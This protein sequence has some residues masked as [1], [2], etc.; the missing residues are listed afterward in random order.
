MKKIDLHVHTV[1]TI[2]DSQFVFSLDVFKRYVSEAKLEAV[3][4]TNH[5][6]FDG[7][8][9]RTIRDTFEGVAVFPGIEG[10]VGKGHVFI[11][12][13]GVTLEDFAAQENSV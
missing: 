2:S 4:V 8:Q 11:I 12:S 6:L 5:D 1:P 9:F 10:N 3:A 13:D 7:A